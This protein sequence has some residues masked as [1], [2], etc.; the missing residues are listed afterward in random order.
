MNWLNLSLAAALVFWAQARLFSQSYEP[1]PVKSPDESTVNAIN[2]KTAKLDQALAALRM[3]GVKDPVLAEIEIYHKA[4]T[5]I[6]RHNEFYH[7]DAG[8]WTLA[9]LDRGL[10]RAQQA[11]GGESPWHHQ[12]GWPVVRAYRSRIDG[13]V[14]PFA[15]TFPADYDKDRQKKWRLDVVLHGR[16]PSLT[17][18]KFL[19]Q[20]SGGR[21]APEDQGFIR[22]DIF[23]RGNN[24]YRWAGESDVLEAIDA[25]VAVERMFGRDQ[26][27]DPTRVVLRGF[28]M[29]GA[30]TWQLGLHRPDRW[31]V[32]GPG[33]G[34]TTTHGYVKNLP[35]KLPS[36][37]E[38]CLHIYDAVDYAENALNV[39]VVAYAGSDDPQLAAALNIQSRLQSRKIPMTLLI[40]PGL[41]HTF[42]PEWQQKAETE[43]AKYAGPGKGRKEYPERIHFVTYTLKYPSCAWVEIFGLEQHYDRALVDA[44]KT[45]AGFAVKTANVRTLHLGMPPGSVAPFV[46]SID[47]QQVQARPYI[48]PLGSP[49][50]YLDKRNGQWQVALPQKLVTDRLRQIQKITGLQGPIDDAFTDGFLCVRGTGKPW[51]PA[52][53]K[54][55][56]A[57]LR[58]FQEEWDK[59]LRADLPIKDDVEITDEDIATKH[60][61]LF[62]DP[63]SNSLIAQVLDGLSLKWTPDSITFDKQ[64]YSAAN[65]VPMLIYPSPLNTGRYVVLNSGHTFHAA[66]FRGTNALLFPRLGDYAILKL[67]QE[68]DPLATEVAT[69]GLFDDF[70]RF[71]K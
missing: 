30:G 7:A 36:D 63:G 69:A 8:S 37:Q 2:A 16:D 71:K 39:P 70:W 26:H 10:L 5:W 11:S 58:R 21:V 45:E 51:H 9:V 67:P 25:F 13:S 18:V 27:L 35:E 23:G 12:F 48:T 49:N 1:P 20:F 46:V 68:N 34:F 40:A 19:H 31:C 52:T 28:S 3:Q 42:P 57:N 38:S 6:V 53:A 32:L 4:A 17:E 60:L 61:I 50:L 22:L 65:H 64:T 43:Y 56:E 33:A 15:V 55:A 66:E 14:Q 54:H 59:F 62:G 24:A 41:G 29:G 47:G 44:Q